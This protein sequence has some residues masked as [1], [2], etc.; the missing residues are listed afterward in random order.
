M[1]STTKHLILFACMI[2]IQSCGYSALTL[3]LSPTNILYLNSSC[4]QDECVNKQLLDGNGGCIYSPIVKKEIIGVLNEDISNLDEYNS[5]DMDTQV[6]IESIYSQ[7]VHHN[8]TA[9]KSVSDSSIGNPGCLTLVFFGLTISKIVGIVAIVVLIFLA[10]YMV[11]R[12]YRKR[13]NNNK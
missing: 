8:K 2:V 7:C 6:V 12:K 3:A 5:L 13:R 11:I 4:Y 9:E 10:V 1:R